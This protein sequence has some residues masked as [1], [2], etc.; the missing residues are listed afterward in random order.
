MSFK[1]SN[2]KKSLIDPSKSNKK[3]HKGQLKN[4]KTKYL[5]SKY[6]PENQKERK[7]TYFQKEMEKSK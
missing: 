3:R 2:F 5:M 7:M 4:Q 1:D 6:L